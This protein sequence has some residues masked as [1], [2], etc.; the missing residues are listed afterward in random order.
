MSNASEFSIPE[1]H[2]KG[3][4]DESWIH[5]DEKYCGKVLYFQNGKKCSLHYHKLKHETFFLQ[6][7]YLECRFFPLENLE[8]ELKTPRGLWII[9]KPGDVKEIPP[10]LVHQMKA[11]MGDAY[12]YEFST[13]HFEDDS[14]RIEKGD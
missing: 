8:N 14:Y 11:I 6:S 1:R 9:M 10:G 7:G 5:N 13:Q 2:I 3:W 4:G 12:L